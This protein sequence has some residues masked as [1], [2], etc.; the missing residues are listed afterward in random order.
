MNPIGG[1]ARDED[2]QGLVQR[3]SVSVPGFALLGRD[4]GGVWMRDL[5][6]VGT[7]QG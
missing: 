3:F 5:L 4:M 1:N 6:L 7:G 2:R